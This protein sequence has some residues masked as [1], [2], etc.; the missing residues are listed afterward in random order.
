MQMRCI[1][2]ECMTD[3]ET[4]RELNEEEKGVEEK[5]NVTALYL[6]ENEGFHS[7]K[8]EGADYKKEAHRHSSNPV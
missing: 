4:C 7:S 5:I 2:E 1:G 6:L 3:D 8:D